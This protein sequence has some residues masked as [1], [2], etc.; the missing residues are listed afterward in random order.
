M[1]LF[2][3]AAVGKTYTAVDKS[4]TSASIAPGRW[5]KADEFVMYTASTIAMTVLETSA[6]VTARKGLPLNKFLVEVNVPDDVWD[7]RTVLTSLSASPGWDAIPAGLPSIQDGSNWYVSGASALLEV[8]SVIVPE[9]S[10]VL[11]NC[12]HSDVTRIGLRIIRKHTYENLLG[13]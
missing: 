7:A 2:R 3:I 4:G 11:I 10:C 5:N 9:E 12:I 1:I 6:H 13:R 8:P